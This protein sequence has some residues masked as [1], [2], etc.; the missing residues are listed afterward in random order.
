MSVSDPVV[1]R[2]RG[3][4]SRTHPTS[5]ALVAVIIA[6][7]LLALVYSVVNP[8]FEAN[9]EFQ[10]FYTALHL[11]QGRGFARPDPGQPWLQEAAQP[12]LYYLLTAGLIAPVD[13]SDAEHLLWNN[14]FAAKGLPTA[15]ANKNR[16]IHTDRERWPY[17]QTVLAVH[18]ARAFSVLLG[19]VTVGLI[20]AIVRV[21]LPA[22][23]RVALAA[24]A[25]TA[26]T[27]Q[28]LFLS[29][30]VSND[31]M[32]NVTAALAA[33]VLLSGLRGRRPRGWAMMLGVALGLTGLS[34]TSNLLLWPLVGLVILLA[35]WR[36]GRLR[37]SMRDLTVIFALASVLA[38]WWYAR[39]WL[40]YSDPTGVAS[41]VGMIGRR[42]APPGF[43]EMV[44]ELGPFRFSY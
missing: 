30:S 15:F 5:I 29:A 16:T 8:I 17:Q 44:Q 34:K 35:G 27:P 22:A 37:H 32:A 41:I 18:L 4:F 36:S 23:P 26:F 7:V 42:A 21:V 12:P 20:Y 11:A 10:H 43:G 40:I 13:T 38:G 33:W 9:D 25:L 19:A 39:N 1:I 31:N 6:F 2:R 3:A 28:F 24:A 14:E